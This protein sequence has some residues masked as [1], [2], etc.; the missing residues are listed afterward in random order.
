MQDTMFLCMR[1]IIWMFWTVS[2]CDKKF[3]Q[4]HWLD[5]L[6]SLNTMFFR[7]A[8]S[9]LIGALS[10]NSDFNVKLFSMCSRH[11][12][13]TSMHWIKK[14]GTVNTARLQIRHLGGAWIKLLIRDPWDDER[15]FDSKAV[16]DRASRRGSNQVAHKWPV[17]WRAYV[18]CSEAVDNFASSWDA[19]FCP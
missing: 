3:Q 2:N 5:N 6:N 10:N 7:Y 4:H 12:L 8:I 14:L 13:S 19:F 17:R 15:V 18:R 9:L 1:C 11:S 16:A